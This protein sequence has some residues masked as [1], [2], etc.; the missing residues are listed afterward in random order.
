MTDSPLHCPNQIPIVATGEAYV[1][2]DGRS[3]VVRKECLERR[4]VRL[5]VGNQVFDCQIV[6]TI[7]Q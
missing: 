6:L 2:D 7:G 5:G 4:I 1:N 3:M